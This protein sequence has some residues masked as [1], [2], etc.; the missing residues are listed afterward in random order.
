MK[1]TSFKVRNT[2]KVDNSYETS[3]GYQLMKFSLSDG[4]ED[5]GIYKGSSFEIRLIHLIQ[6]YNHDTHKLTFFCKKC[7]L[8]NHFKQFGKPRAIINSTSSI[9]VTHN[10]GEDWYE[11]CLEEPW[12]PNGCQ[13]CGIYKGSPF[14]DRLMNLICLNGQKDGQFLCEKCLKKIKPKDL[15]RQLVE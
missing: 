9:I 8:K 13:E 4:C 11:Y 10:I 1:R 5:C 6:S 12:L 2:I 15:D 14:E 3:N 7:Y